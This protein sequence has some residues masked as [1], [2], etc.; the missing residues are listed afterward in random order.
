MCI[1]VCAPYVCFCYMLERESERESS[2]GRGRGAGGAGGRW[3]R[4][5]AVDAAESNTEERGD[6]EDLGKIA[7]KREGRERRDRFSPGHV[8]WSPGWM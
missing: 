2:A 3:G 4:G 5:A 1:C 7:W 8:Q 6:R